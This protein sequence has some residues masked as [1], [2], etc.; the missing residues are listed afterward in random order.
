MGLGL[1]VVGEN[2]KYLVRDQ[3][4]RDL[5]GWLFGAA[6]WRATA[7]DQ[8]IGWDQTPRAARRPYLANN[9]RYLILPWVQVA[10]LASHLL[11]QA[12]Q[13]VSRDWQKKYGHPI[14]LLES[15]VEAG[16]FEGTC[17]RAANWLCVGQTCGRGRQGPN[18]MEP[19]QP[20]KDI[21]LYPLTRHFRRHLLEGT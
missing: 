9:T 20:R 21:Y 5:A 12:A 15:F 19:T 16:R 11:S 7:R 6:A 2:M 1:R 8:R 13:R 17:Y 3:Q 4:G 14:Y 18:P 10:G